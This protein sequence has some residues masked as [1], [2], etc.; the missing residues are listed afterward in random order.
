MVHAYNTNLARWYAAYK[1]QILQDSRVLNVT[2]MEEALGSKTQTATYQPEGSSNNQSHQIPRLLGHFDFVETLGMEMAA[3]RGY[4]EEFRADTLNSIIIN[5]AAA[6]F[7][8]WTPEEAI[9]KRIDQGI[10][11]Q[12]LSRQIVGVIKDFNY[13]SLHHPI[14]PFILE[15]P[16]NQ[17][18]MNIFMRYIAVKVNTDDFQSTI[19]F[20]EEKFRDVV[21]NR[22]FEYFFLDDNLNKLYEAEDKM[23]K[24]FTAFSFLA[25]FI[26]CLGLFALASFTAEQRTKEVGIR[27]VMGASVIG[28]VG[29]ISKEFLLLVIAANVIAWPLANFVMDNWL[30]TF[31]YRIYFGWVTFFLSGLTALVI[32]MLTVSYQAFKAANANPV[33]SIRND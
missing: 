7:F 26:A 22:S 17:F 9:G 29:L 28:I 25:I 3:G 5:E 21:P 19:A 32:A 10:G 12:V 16:Q 15:L 31:A 2:V 1:G 18:Q 23:S 11:Q 6:K 4:S 8:G 13:A 27:K 24:V 30:D 33:D 14:K 20:L